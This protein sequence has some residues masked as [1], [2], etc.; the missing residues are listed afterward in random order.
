MLTTRKTTNQRTYTIKEKRDA[1]RQASERGVQDAAD[2]LGY[3]RRT[4]G[5]WVSQAHSIFNFKGS[6]MSKTLKGLGRK[7]MIPFSHR[8]V[9][10]MKDMRRDEEVRS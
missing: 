1:I 9:T 7:K 4:V 10:L 8:L 3:P 5:D 6:Q 2:Y